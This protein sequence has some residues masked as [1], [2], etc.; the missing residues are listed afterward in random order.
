MPE[1]NLSYLV[2]LS[3]YYGIAAWRV[4][5][6]LVEEDGPFELGDKLRHLVGVRHDVYSNRYSERE[7]GK[8]FLCVKCMSIWLAV[9]FILLHSAT[10]IFSV[11]CLPIAISGVASLWPSI[12]I[13]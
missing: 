9:L 12:A 4:A 10:P 1:I 8:L 3:L 6:L 7:L 2:L 5:F 11:L 13:R